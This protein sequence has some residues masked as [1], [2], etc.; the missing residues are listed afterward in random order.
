[1]TETS[2]KTKDIFIEICPKCNALHVLKIAGSLFEELGRDETVCGAAFGSTRD[3]KTG[4]ITAVQCDYILKVRDGADGNLWTIRRWTFRERQEF[5]RLIGTFGRPITPG[6]AEALTIN[7][8]PKIMDYAINTCLV[9]GPVTLKTKEEL[10]NSKFDGAILEALYSQI[11]AWNSPPLVQSSI[12]RQRSIPT[13][14]PLPPT[15]N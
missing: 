12:S 1:M 10:D 15:T 8:D 13:I 14:P 3:P 4:Q 6:S 2:T 7:I 11:I 9:K 5:Y